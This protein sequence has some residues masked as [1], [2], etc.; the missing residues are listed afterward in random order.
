MAGWKDGIPVQQGQQGGLK[1][2]TD[3]EILRQL[4][5]TTPATPPPPPPGNALDKPKWQQGIP[6]TPKWQ[7]GKP[8]TDPA[9][10]QQLNQ[11]AAPPAMSPVAQ[12][13]LPVQDDHGNI[14]I[15]PEVHREMDNLRAFQDEHRLTEPNSFMGGIADAATGTGNSILE[16]MMGGANAMAKGGRDLGAGLASLPFDVA[17]LVSPEAGD[18]GADV[19]K[20]IPQVKTDSKPQD[21]IAAITQYGAPA[22]AGAK[23]AGGLARGA[24][25]I[26][27]WITRLLAAAGADTAVTDPDQATT[28]GSILPGDLGKGPTAI[29]ADDSPHPVPVRPWAIS[30][31]YSPRARASPLRRR[32]RAITWSV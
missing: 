4:N 22:A 26:V 5:S 9:L 6:V 15:M 27:G 11:P 16:A 17:G 19:R 12:A 31:A 13:M 3:P 14:N 1:P 23:I 32:L 2:V 29:E 24:P 8:V 20:A 25:A 28:I 7:Q 30:I 21:I 18:I 10:L